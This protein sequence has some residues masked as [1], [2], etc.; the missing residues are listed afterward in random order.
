MDIRLVHDDDVTLVELQGALDVRGAR[1]LERSLAELL[2]TTGVRLALDCSQI[3]VTTG[4][5]LRGLVALSQ[6]LLLVDGALVLY[7]LDTQ[8]LRVFDVA[9]LA[10]RFTIVPTAVEAV[11]RLRT[12]G[13]P[14]TLVPP[15]RAVIRRLATRVL[16]ALEGS[17]APPPA[18]RTLHHLRRPA[19]SGPALS[20]RVLALLSL[21]PEGGA[22]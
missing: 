15:G 2:R 9:E 13:A 17:D 8:L 1:D 3:D 7:A 4:A 16:A 6:R 5:G 14:V 20:A 18:A 22:S 19:P 11:L 12:R 21:R 10:E